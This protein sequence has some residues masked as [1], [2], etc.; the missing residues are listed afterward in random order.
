MATPNTAFQK[1][2]APYAVQAGKLLGMDPNVIMTQ[3]LY[4]TNDGTN[5]GSRLYNNLA[6]IKHTGSS[7]PAAY[8]VGDSIHAAYPTLSDFVNDYVRVLKL[9]YYNEIRAI[10]KPGV[11]PIVAKNVIDKSPYAVTNYNQEGWLRFFNQ[12]KAVL[13]S[14]VGAGVGTGTITPPAEKKTIQP[15]LCHHCQDKPC[16]L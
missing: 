9:S 1:K 15:C 16:N 2:I 4:E 7:T 8:T 11:D 13:G 12:A 6:G 10:A 14:G 3:W 5:V